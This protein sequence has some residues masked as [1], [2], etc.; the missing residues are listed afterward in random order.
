[1][2]SGKLFVLSA[3]A[4]FVQGAIDLDGHRVVHPVSEDDPS[5]IADPLSYI[6]DQHNCP[7]PCYV[8]YANVHRWT[9]Y[10]SLGRLQ[11]CEL[12]MLLHFSVL[13]PLDDPNTDV[14]IRTC[15]LGTDPASVGDRTVSNATSTPIDNPKLGD[16]LLEPSKNV[17]P[18]CFIDGRETTGEL[19]LATGDGKA[20]RGEALGLLGGMKEFFTATDNC[21]ETFLFAYHRQTVASVHIGSG[22]GKRT[23]MSALQAVAG[24]LQD[25]ESTAN[26]TIAQI[27][28]DGRGPET[29][30]GISID[31]TG[32]LVGI[33][34][35]TVAWSQGDCVVG[36]D[37]PSPLKQET[38]VVSVFDIASA[39]LAD[40]GGNIT[41]NAA[42]NHTDYSN[43]TSAS[44]QSRSKM[45]SHPWRR[46][47]ALA[48][49][50]T[51]TYIRVEAGDGCASLAARCGIRGVDFLRY[52]PKSDLCSTLQP[53]DYVCCSAGDPYSEPKP[54]APQPNADGSCA[55][56]FI[57]NF[58][59]CASLGKTYGLTEAQIESF[60][61]GKTWGWTECRAMLAGYNMCLSTGTPPLPPPQQGTQCG[62][63]V[64]GTEW[65]DKSITMADLNPCPLKACCSNWGFC[66]PFP[67]HCDIHAP[68]GGGPGAKLPEFKSTCISNCGM[69]IKQNSGPPANFSRIGYYESWNMG[70]KC[71][72]MKAENANVDTSYTHIHWGFAEIDP[73]TWTVVL[74]DPHHQWQAFKNLQGVKRIV[75]FGGW[76]YST[77]PA[78]YNIIRQAI[79]TNRDKFATNA[80]KFVMD[81][82]LD[83]IDIDWEY[84]GAPDIEVNGVP[85]GQPGDGVAYLRFL[86]VLKSKLPTKSVS[87]AAPASYWY[88]KA[89]PIDRIAAV[90]D[91]IVY[92]TY[93]LHGQWD[94]GNPN[95]FD[96]CLSGKC[97]RSH[98]NL[99]E[100]YNMLAVVTKAGVPNNKIFV[101]ESS[102]GRSFRMA[103]DGC[104]GPLC[105]F[106]G[107]KLQSDANPGRCTD[108]RGYISNAEINEII[109]SGEGEAFHDHTC[110]VDVLLWKG[111]YISYLTPTTK[112]TRR[113]AWRRRNFAGTIDW[114]LDLQAFGPDDF[115]VPPDRPAA[116]EEAC[117]SGTSSDLNAYDLC[118]F[119]C[120]YGF[121]PESTC[122][123][124]L[125]GPAE[126]LPAVVSTG[127]FVAWDDF[128]ADMNR[129]CKFACKYGFCPPKSCTTPVVDEYDDGTVDPTNLGGI[130]DRDKYNDLD[131]K[132]CNL[133][134][135]PKYRY[136]E[137]CLDACID[138]VEQAKEQGRTTNYG[139]VGNFPLDQEIPWTLWPGAGASDMLY[140]PGKCVCDHTLVN[141][142][143]DTI[144]EAL[145]IIAQV[146]CY[147]V[148]SAFKLVLD[149]GLAAIP[150]VGKILDAGLDTVTTAA[151]ML[152]YA[153][154]PDQDPIGAFE[155]WLSPCGG[156]DLVPDEVKRVFEVLSTVVDGVSSFKEPPNIQRNSGRK[157]DDANPT[158]RSKPKAGNGSGPNGIGSGGIRK[159]RRCSIRPLQSTIIVGNPDNTLRY[160]SCTPDGNGGSTTTKTDMVITSLV[161]GPTP[162]TIEQVCSK[163]W[164][165]ACYHYS[166]AI[167]QNPQWGV[168]ECVHGNVKNPENDRPGVR[169][170]YSQADDSWRD[171]AYRDAA[172]CDADEYPPRYFLRD[173]DPEMQKA[174]QPGG[175][176]MR[177]LP[178][179]ENQDAGRSWKGVCFAP[180]IA[181][182]TIAEFKKKFDAV[183]A[184][185]RTTV[186]KKT[187]RY[188]LTETKV[189][190]PVD[191]KPYFKFSSFE[192]AANP[193]VDA[194]MWD[195]G[196][197]PKKVAPKEPG[198]TLWRWD[199]WYDG[200][201]PGHT[202]EYDFTEP[203]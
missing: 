101:G 92:M 29:V 2:K 78:T 149:V 186:E 62:P 90:I 135:Y 18:A 49:R 184:K 142:F 200:R 38:L 195:N 120:N 68:E 91:Y 9:P 88:L 11:R 45:A 43:A 17:A 198:F 76:A 107:T 83:G 174:G 188:K 55:V 183:P 77:E 143:A 22:L 147:V 93:D 151:Q 197:W 23:A 154:P 138:A 145:P 27:C 37:L 48:G 81:E 158:D 189:K 56:H 127:D 115:D 185:E 73:A 70:R 199:Q 74:K 102:Y 140:V 97:I 10:Y 4:T 100:T 122:E 134:K 79:I 32:D 87:I 177:Y 175:Q 168:L 65:T 106:T 80:A 47:Q 71:L 165:Q 162:T 171:G 129:L 173:S 169:K 117:I 170:W 15:T 160:Q 109:R 178:S 96:S 150:G 146:G 176:L 20:S 95:A 13:L 155:W 64:P 167:A 132:T 121:C 61:K 6:P 152:S 123:C 66:G 137:E 53:G 130:M 141:F 202:H 139:C 41:T 194:G 19:V 82:G 58:D 57:R 181:D 28:G 179:Q 34:K 3:A 159:R 50:A 103:V 98:V 35:M 166:S 14:L 84:P 67:E 33:Q 203:V 148:M 144:V 31:T 36:S 42:G 75:S 182:L 128:N 110:N 201:T 1:M 25:D 16:G 85:I 163:A 136:K 192:H 46:A 126:P 104:W 156:T 157:G 39:P 52:N 193:P 180:H 69:E 191:V 187:D 51:C 119:A 124:L 172:R 125:M 153:Y 105:D 111:D 21:D 30:F 190:V 60:N 133:W 63:L 94:Y 72:W 86:T 108:T 54:Q 24:R 89:F 40:D 99:T 161:F 131:K 44:I 26:R 59:T 7:L 12:P 5:P 196:C 116:G 112:E 118:E 114:A 8:D 113:A 164:S